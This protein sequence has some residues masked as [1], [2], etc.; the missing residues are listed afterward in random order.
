MES[1]YIGILGCVI[2][3]IISYGV[4]YLVNLAVPMILAATSGA[5]R[6]I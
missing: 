2:G 6:A 5:M 1:A 3:I 4:S